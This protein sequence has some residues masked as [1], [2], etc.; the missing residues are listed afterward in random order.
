MKEEFFTEEN[1]PPSLWMKFLKVEDRIKGTLVSVDHKP[2]DG[3]FP[4]QMVYEL[5]VKN[6]DVIVSDGDDQEKGTWYVGISKPYLLSKLKKAKLGQ[7]IGF[8][9]VKEIPSTKKGY[10]PAKS[11]EV[12]LGQM[13]SEWNDMGD[14]ESQ[15]MEEP[16]FGDK[17]DTLREAKENL[18]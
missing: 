13:D 15:G 9:F 8:K 1:I 2:G 12:Y 3:D 5:E 10:Q 14:M 6:D 11:I 7:K 18:G 17:S 4:D 16:P